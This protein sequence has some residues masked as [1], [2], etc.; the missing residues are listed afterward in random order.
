[1]RERG[2]RRAV[3]K[4]SVSAAADLTIR[5]EQGQPLPDL[6]P[7]RARGE[8]LVQ[9][10]LTEIEQAGEWSFVFFSG[11]FSHSLVKRPRAGDFR[12]QEQFGGLHAAQEPPP[13][14]LQQAE[15]ALRAAPGPTLYARVDGCVVGGQF[16]VME[17][18]LL[19]PSLFLAL[20]PGAP[21]RFAAALAEVLVK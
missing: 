20:D 21:E 8:V 11:R 14:L 10:Y 9:P 7:L 16:L 19:E 18:E 6:A 15:R 13:W 4:P 1:M 12:V 3:V 17:L 5:V 2:W